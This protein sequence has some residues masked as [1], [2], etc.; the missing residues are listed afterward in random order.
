MKFSWKKNNNSAEAAPTAGFSPTTDMMD[1]A[2]TV[3]ANTLA[4][5]AMDYE[6][7]VYSIS[8]TG[9]TRTSNEDAV[10]SSYPD[11]SYQCL[12]AMVADGMGGHNAGEVA[13]ALACETLKAWVQ[14]KHSAPNASAMLSDGILE[15]HRVIQAAGAG[16]EAQKGMGTTTTALFIRNGLVHYAHVGDSRLYQSSGGQWRQ[17]T[18][19]HT[20]V[21]QLVASGELAPEEAAGHPMKNYITQAVGYTKTITPETAA[22]AIPVKAGD[23]YLIISDGVYDVLSGD[24]LG[25]LSNITRP[26]LLLECIRALCTERRSSDN[27]SVVLITVSD[28][29]LPLPPI[30]KEQNAVL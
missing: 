16:N 9:P 19:D 18:T 3:A 26:E 28:D 5:Q 20:L 15:A 7:K 23:R 27:F 22:T 25:A 14:Q 17:L 30:T 6:Y 29:L 4:A 2:N 8:E 12:F 21:N 13:S 24:E 10:C 11:G 1:T